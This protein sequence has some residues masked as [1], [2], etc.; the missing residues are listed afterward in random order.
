MSHPATVEA[1]LPRSFSSHATPITLA[2]GDGERSIREVCHDLRQ[3]IAT[4]DTLMAAAQLAPELPGDAAHFLDLARQEVDLLRA[5]CRQLVERRSKPHPLR[6][7]HVV[8]ALVEET[9][10]RW[11]GQVFLASEPCSI[12]AD[13]LE[14]RRVLENLLDNAAKA[15]GPDGNVN[16]TVRRRAGAVIIEVADSGPGFSH[17]TDRG[18]GLGLMIV[19]Q[20]SRRLGWQALV[21]NSRL[22]GAVVR[23]VIPDAHRPEES[24]Q[25]SISEPENRSGVLLIPEA[26]HQAHERLRPDKVP[27]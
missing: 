10:A 2:D 22:G 7:D 6:L 24:G 21:D 14:L 16:V 15:A 5:F 3:H 9:Q 12:V 23:L 19:E 27:T 20:L 26:E 11:A 17:T 1:K 13:E 8:A 18:T 4:I 25:R